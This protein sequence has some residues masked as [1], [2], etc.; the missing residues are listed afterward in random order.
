MLGRRSYV[1]FC[2]R[3]LLVYLVRMD[4]IPRRNRPTIYLGPPLPSLVTDALATVDV[5]TLHRTATDPRSLA[6]YYKPGVEAWYAHAAQRDG[7]AVLIPG[8][9]DHNFRLLSFLRLY[10]APDGEF[11]HLDVGCGAGL[12]ATSILLQYPGAR[13]TAI[14][15]SAANLEAANT[16]ATRLGVSD[17][18]RLVQADAN[19]LPLRAR[20]ATIVCS[21]IIEHLPDP[22]PL[23]RTLRSFCSEE[24]RLYVSVPQL[25]F[26]NPTDFMYVK[27]SRDGAKIDEAGEIE[28]LQGDGPIVA[29]YH[30]LYQRD[31]IESSL[32]KA[33]FAVKSWS[34]AN[35]KF[36]RRLPWISYVLKKV[37]RSA[38]LDARLNQA[39]GQ[40]FAGNI[41]VAAVPLGFNKPNGKF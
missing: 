7:D 2:W 14:D 39:T 41:Q 11:E 18:L 36:P 8:N 20:P 5:E 24:T 19:M 15:I 26:R 40:R 25:N 37:F 31:E 1:E 10:S 22:L 9:H 21:E 32:R 34:G 4:Q 12:Y 38:T 35:L 13:V 6:D 33:G 27:L 28:Q 30:H 3:S 29:Y 16:L 23:L 17:R